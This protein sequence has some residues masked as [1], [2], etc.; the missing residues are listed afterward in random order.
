MAD[1]LLVH[2]LFHGAWEWAKLWG[3]ITAPS[4]VPL[5]LYSKENSRKVIAMD[6]PLYKDSIGGEEYSMNFDDIVGEIVNEASKLKN[7]V[8]VGHGFSAP[9][10]LRAACQLDTPPKCAVIFAGI[11]PK[12]GQRILDGLPFMN[13]FGIRVTATLSKVAKKQPTLPKSIINR[14]YC[15]GLDPFE[16]I[17]I[18]GRFTHIPTNFLFH[19]IDHAD[20]VPDCPVIYVPIGRNKLIPYSRQLNMANMINNVAVEEKVE[21]CHEV[22]IENPSAVADILLKHD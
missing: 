11:I 17:Q 5:K 22:M 9:L 3:L 14:V 19:R 2:D 13:K 16:T 15:N 10:V 20:I 12:D 1:F 8:L 18:I 7:P 4:N 6:L 21:S